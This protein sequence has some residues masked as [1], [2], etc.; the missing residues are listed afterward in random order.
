MISVIIATKNETKNIERI[1]TSLAEQ[2]HQ[3]FEVIVVDNNSTD[4]TL[5]LARKTASN[6]NA[7]PLPNQAS[8]GKKNFRGAQINYGTQIAKGDKYFFPDADM[9]FNRNLL[10]EANQLLKNS[11]ALFVPEK[12]IGKGAFGEIRNFER[13]FYDTTC[14]DAP[15]FVTKSIFEKVGGFDEYN[16]SFG[17]D[18]W[19]FN[20]KLNANTQNIGITK[21]EIF[22]HETELSFFDYLSKKNNYVVTFDDYK[23]KWRGHPALKKQFGFKY[24]YFV[25]FV[26]NGKWQK[27]LGNPSLA[28]AM[29]GVRILVG[30][31]YCLRRIFK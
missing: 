3:D 30:L 15:R 18:D 29:F 25:V 2:T 22:H 19:D 16:M 14:I 7:I 11:E 20:L 23:K 31:I 26:E 13:S 1:L 4:G 5:E 9:T 28:F 8:K 24:R 21:S 12:I 27:L 6:I 10:E 17:P